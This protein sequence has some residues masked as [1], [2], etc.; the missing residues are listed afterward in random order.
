MSNL[1]NQNIGQNYRGILNLDATTINTPL[2]ATL[3]AVTDGTGTSSPLQL[4][5]TSIQFGSSTGL[6]WNNTTSRLGL[7][8]NSPLGVLHLKTT[9]ATTRLLLDGDAAQ[10]KIITYRT[11]GLQRFGLYTNNTAESGANAGSDFAIRAYSDAGTLLST[12]I[13]IKRSTGN[14]GIGTTTP[15]GKLD[16]FNAIALVAGATNPRLFNVAY[17]INNSG[18]QTGTLTGIFLNATE[19]ALNGMSHNLMDLQVGGVSRFLVSRT[20]QASLSSL[21]TT[22][23]IRGRLVSPSG[24]QLLED[25]AGGTFNRLQLGGTTNAFPSIK[26][27]GTAIDFRL[28]D[29]SAACDINANKFLVA[30]NNGMAYDGTI[31]AVIGHVGASGGSG[32]NVAF[33]DSDNAIVKYGLIGQTGFAIRDTGAVGTVSKNSTAIM[34]LQSTTKGFLM[35]RMTYAQMKAISTP[36]TGLQIYNTTNNTPQVYDGTGYQILGTSLVVGTISAGATTLSCDNGNIFEL[37]L[38]SGTPTAITLSNARP[39]SVIINLKQPAGGSALVTWAT[40]IVWAGGSP[41]TLTT[42]AN[43]LDVITLIFDGTTWRGTATLNFAS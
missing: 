35:P 7:G 38:V 41:P 24:I 2:D 42:T 18:V 33:A 37:T 17:T 1:Y 43:F 13:F 9:G 6:F 28:A 3:R 19:T 27:N 4:S 23:F 15:V 30:S 21:T 31:G 25:T 22:D 14:V 8:T 34:D 29:D 32:W 39:T 11:A 10:S 5:T 20:G 16:V 36:A 40:T 26:R 12:P